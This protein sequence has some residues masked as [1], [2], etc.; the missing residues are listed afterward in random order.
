[1]MDIMPCNP[2]LA[3]C[4]FLGSIF[5]PEDGGDMFFR[6]GYKALYFRRQKSP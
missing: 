5:S 6:N 3:A 2:L 4:F 1:M